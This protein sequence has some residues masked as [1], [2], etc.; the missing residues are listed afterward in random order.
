MQSG[1]EAAG[2]QLISDCFHSL[3]REQKAERMVIGLVT[4]L[5]TRLRMQT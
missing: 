2:Y 4:A 1:E 5:M 3:T